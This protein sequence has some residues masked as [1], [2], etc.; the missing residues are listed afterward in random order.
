[1]TRLTLKR[2]EKSEWN[3]APLMAPT[4]KS[5]F[6]ETC[7]M[8]SREGTQ[9]ISKHGHSAVVPHDRPDLLPPDLNLRGLGLTEV[10]AIWARNWR[11][12]WRVKELGTNQGR[13]P[14][15]SNTPAPL[16]ARNMNPPTFRMKNRLPA[17]KM[18]SSRRQ[19][20]M[21]WKLNLEAPPI[22]R[23]T[24]ACGSLSTGLLFAIPLPCK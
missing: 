3:S 22:L 20:H 14:Q 15:K 2:T 10:L 12:S 8:S 7:T 23:K 9:F 13:A 18:P 6:Q 24:S 11:P 16:T 1:M 21:V 19:F 4:S 5:P 17:L